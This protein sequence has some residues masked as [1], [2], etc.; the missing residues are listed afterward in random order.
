MTGIEPASSAWEAD[1][2]PMNYICVMIIITDDFSFEK[3]FFLF[4]LIFSS[5]FLR[6][7]LFLPLVFP[8]V[9]FYTEYRHFI[10][11]FIVG[12]NLF[13]NHKPFQ[14]NAFI[15]GSLHFQPTARTGVQNLYYIYPLMLPAA[16]RFSAHPNL[17]IF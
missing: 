10:P 6:A 14:S 3:P 7:F 13:P 9:L 17:I 4:F 1:V 12:R 11:P 2:L 5:F 8:D 15:T 16:S